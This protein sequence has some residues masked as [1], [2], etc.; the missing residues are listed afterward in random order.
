MNTLKFFLIYVYE[1]Y[2]KTGNG[3]VT[4]SNILIQIECPISDDLCE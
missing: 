1:A 4:S 3:K 2:S